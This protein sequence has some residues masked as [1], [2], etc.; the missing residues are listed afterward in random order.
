MRDVSQP[1]AG[2]DGIRLDEDL[3]SRID[4]TTVEQQLEEQ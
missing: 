1:D 3:D 4:W 2:A